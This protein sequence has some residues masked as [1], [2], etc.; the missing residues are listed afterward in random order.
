MVHKAWTAAGGAPSRVEAIAQTADGTL[1]LANQKGLIRFDGVRFIR[2][3][4]PADRPFESNNISAV[5]ASANGGLW[6]GFRFGGISFLNNGG[7]VHYGEK[8][9]LPVS[10]VNKILT[11]PEGVTYAAT[12]QGLFRLERNRWERVVVDESDPKA[13]TFNAAVD[14][15]GTLWVATDAALW[16]RPR[17]AAS[18]RVI[19]KQNQGQPRY[20]PLTRGPD[21]RIWVRNLN[22]PGGVTRLDLLTDSSHGGFRELSL[23]DPES[24]G[25]LF[26]HEGNLWLTGRAALHRFAAATLIGDLSNTAQRM[27]SFTIADGLS[28][29][30]TCFFEDREGNI[31][32]GTDGGL[33]RF[34]P[35]NIVRIIHPNLG[36]A[37]T[38]AGEAGTVWANGGIASGNGTYPIF[39]ISDNAVVREYS[40]PYFSNAYRNP[41]GIL[42]FG[43]W[44]GIARFDAGRLVTTALPEK[45]EVQAMV[46]DRTGAMWVS[47]VRKGVFRF[48]DG[49][50]LLN[51][52]L[53]ALPHLP[54]IVETADASGKLWFGYTGNQIARIDGST[55]KLFG[56]ADGLD[57]G[58]VT[59]IASRL[60]H[61]WIAGE[62]GLARFDGTRFVPVLSASS[63]FPGI[64]GIVELQS[65]DLWLNGD[66]GIVHIFRSEVEKAEHA[67]GYRVQGE[68][69]DYLDGIAGTARQLRPTPSAFQGTDGRLWFLTQNELVSVDPSR[70]TRNTLAPPVTIWSISAGGVQYPAGLPPQLPPHTS[71][72]RIDYTA[73]S[74]TIPER[75]RFRYK[76][77]GFDREW[78]D[79]AN[80][81]EVFYTNVGPG[82]YTFRVIAA[83]NDG[84]WNTT[85]ASLSFTIAPAFYQTT[86]FYGLSVLL[87]LVLLRL[88]YLV[89]IRQVSAH[90]RGRLEE[91][92]A[93]RERI[94]RAL[95]D[96]LLQSFQGL[97]L[98]LRATVARMP[99]QEP[100]RSLME[101]A[102]ERADEVMSESRDRVKDLRS[103]SS[104]ESDLPRALA[105]LGEKL[106]VEQTAHFCSTVE[107]IP[108]DLHPIVREE[109]LFIAREALANAFSH[110]NAHH[111]EVEIS[112][113]EA[114]LRIR[115]RDD[116]DGIHNEL[117]ER[118]G[119]DGHWGLLGMRERAK[120]IRATFTIWSKLG[121]GTEVDLR[122]PAHIAYRSRDRGSIRWW[123]RGSFLDAEG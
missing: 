107:G 48:A 47:V 10:T 13:L 118:G 119:R 116:G 15:S 83:N 52:N 20:L 25:M 68:I 42:W 5:A 23:D 61:L 78:Q 40:G 115:I 102:L 53:P 39:E 7:I 56:T 19:S 92:L 1:W 44:S 94:A 71:N 103:A 80:R 38:M 32:V 91:R 72:L 49:Q 46:Q 114:E 97:V 11:D 57:V 81:R 62:R 2:F 98:R 82:R 43:G 33:D 22:R 106:A 67:A 16:A 88:L 18:F 105:A 112:Y 64:S 96:T 24:Y 113:R 108:R 14:G 26:D 17:E 69:F 4:G 110:A 27:T 65:G 111:I 30:P 100:T 54:A 121:A 93:E 34:S 36:G 90:V 122:V 8:E 59:A 76:L 123:R 99:K 12:Y 55:V 79:A 50:W 101:Q 29:W 70:I 66:V 75:V 104:E 89:R 31:W 74:L 35:S 63:S 117:L 60:G 9:G 41:D 84:V 73:G 51:G 109:A 95:H 6:I 77:E 37:A 87:C 58:N 28:S 45:G 85:G 120:K 21:G 3:D 86:W